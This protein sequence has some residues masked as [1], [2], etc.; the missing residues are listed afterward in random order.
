MKVSKILELFEKIII[1][2]LLFITGLLIIIT[3]YELVVLVVHEAASAAAGDNPRLLLDANELLNVFSFVLLIIIGLELFEAVKQYLNKHILQ[4]EIILIVALTA[5]ARKVIVLDYK[6][7]EPLTI[8]G[9]AF[10][11]LALAVSYFLIKKVNSDT[12][13]G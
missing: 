2:V 8:I 6:N 11:A 4:A 5:I 7:Y 13:K 1:L 3:T 10:L 9:I 12:S